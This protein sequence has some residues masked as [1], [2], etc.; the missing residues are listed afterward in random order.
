MWKLSLGYGKKIKIEIDINN[1]NYWKP[2]GN[3]CET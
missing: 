1:E 3:I 2:Y